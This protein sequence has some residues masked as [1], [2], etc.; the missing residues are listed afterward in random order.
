MQRNYK[1]KHAVTV[2]LS[3]ITLGLQNNTYALGLGDIEV[4]SHLGQPLKAN[5][6]VLGASDIKDTACLRLGN[7]GGNSST[8]TNVSFTLG[9]ISGDI[10]ALSLT[11]ARAV[12]EPILNLSVI[13]DCGSTVQ[14]DYVLLLDPPF[15]STEANSTS[16]NVAAVVQKSDTPAEKSAPVKNQALKKS[17]SNTAAKQRNSKN[18]K[19]AGQK[20]A[21][22]T[23]TNTR[24]KQTKIPVIKK[25]Y[26]SIS[27]GNILGGTVGLRLDRQLTFVPNTNAQLLNEDI[28]IQD[29]VAVMSNRLAH[30]QQQ[31]T[32]LQQQNLKLTSDNNLKTKQLV[33]KIDPPMRLASLF[34][35][36][37][38]GLLF[39]GGYFSLNW[40]RRRMHKQQVESTE[41]IWTDTSEF[42]H[43]AES[44][45]SSAHIEEEDIFADL[46]FSQTVGGAI[47]DLSSMEHNFESTQTADEPMVIEDNNQNFSVL[48]HADVFLSHGR[49]S[50]AIQLLQNHLLDH[51]KQSITIWLFL[52]DLLIKENLKEAYEQTAIDCKAHFNVKISD[53]SMVEIN[54]NKSLEDFP[55]LAEGLQSVWNTPAAVVFLNDL[56]YNNRLEPRTGLDKNLVEELLLLKTVAEENNSTAEVIQLDEKKLV[57]MEQKEA[58]LATKKAEKLQLMIDAEKE[59]QIEKEKIKAKTLAEQSETDFEFN[60]VE[61]K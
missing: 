58:L 20:S 1:L 56:I 49:P 28:A 43:D 5:I 35:F 38:A 7:S 61:F 29:E 27:N 51:P 25:P 45:V 53:F 15:L 46:D 47:G 11:T 3:L 22:V 23:Y 2:A 37:G 13:A 10:A 55:H 33:A 16:D 44:R 31:I 24:Q 54:S 60:L 39:V 4:K 57:L 9:P 8:L 18:K 14:R 40:L 30:L 19:L 41:A 32:S 21:Q 12:N 6:N 34:P 36:M 50:L 59:E 17:I 48:D 52:L 42:S 26:L